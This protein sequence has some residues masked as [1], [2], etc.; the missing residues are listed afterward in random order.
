MLLASAV[1][2]MAWRNDEAAPAR[3]HAVEGAKGRSTY[4]NRALLPP[5]PAPKQASAPKPT[6]SGYVFS[7][8]GDPVAGATVI[9]MTFQ[10]AGNLL[11]TAGSAQSDER[12]RFQLAL[13][14]GTYQLSA[15]ME[16][17]GS[18]SAPA[19]SGATVSL[20]L[21]KSGAVIGHV[22]DERKEPVR[23]FTITAVTS[24]PE[25][26]PAPPPL[27]TKTFDSPDGSFRADQFPN[28]AVFLKVTAAGRAPSFSPALTVGPGETKEVDI[29][30]SSGCTLVGKVEDKT[31]LP[32]PDVLVDAESRLGAG[33]NSELS[34]ASADAVQQ[35]MSEMDGGFRLEHVP[36]GD[37]RV[38]AYDG[39]NAVTTLSLKIT[40]CDKLDPIKVVMSPGGGIAGVARR[41]DGSPLSGARLVLHGRATGFVENVSDAD[42]RFRF[43]ELP[44]GMARLE[45]RYGEQSMMRPV[46]V[47][48]GEITELELNLYEEGTGE[49][50][51]H[52]TARDKPLAGVKLMVT[53]KHGQKGGVSVYYPVTGEAGDYRVPSLP[54]GGY[55][56]TALSTMEGEVAHVNAG[57][58]TTVN[59]D[60]STKPASGD[61]K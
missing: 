27:W 60:V 28:W 15:T 46:R 30:L 42:G 54:D 50:R 49:I 48:D 11:S 25:M 16:G 37:V 45:L 32:L 10:T 33:S 41:A 1:F 36:M 35:A 3:A 9:A 29:S 7:T 39:A 18:T 4:R 19:H 59:L 53:G 2:L 34:M 20:V 57:G 51:G 21:P 40:E 23:R 38:R 24:L 22:Y 58:V 44:P 12:G 31:G 13:P 17:Y 5:P 55:V 43:E 26:L 6:I 61:T 56:I 47:K 52:V 8:E 14:E